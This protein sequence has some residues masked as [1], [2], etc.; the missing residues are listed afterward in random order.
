MTVPKTAAS[1]RKRYLLM[2]DSQTLQPA[3]NTLSS[4]VRTL[5]T[6]SDFRSAMRGVASEP[7][8]PRSSV[9]DDAKWADESVDSFF[10]RRF[11][12]TMAET[13]VSAIIHGIY[14]GDTRRLSMR[15]VFPAL[16]EAERAN[17]SVFRWLWAR[18]RRRT[19]ASRPFEKRRALERDLL[20]MV[21]D[22]IES[23]EKGKALATAMRSASV[24]GLKGG[25]QTLVDH[26][27]GRL[28]DERV[29][30]MT[31]T[32]IDKVERREDRWSLQLDD[33]TSLH[34]DHYVASSPATL[35]PSFSQPSIPKSTV[36]VVSLAF[37]PSEQ[38]QQ[39]L[40]PP[41][42][43][44]LIP[45]VIPASLNPHHA[46]GVIF[47]SDVMPGI[48]ASAE[49]GLTKLSILFGGSYWLDH[50][51]PANQ[52]T[53]DKLVSMA[54]ETL[55]MHFPSVVDWPEPVKTL[56][57]MQVDCIP[58]LPPGIGRD[59]AR[60]HGEMRA[61]NENERMPTVSVV[62]GGPSGVGINAVVQSAWEVGTSIAR[63]IEDDSRRV[64]TGL[65]RWDEAEQ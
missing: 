50:S 27:K 46:L 30:V 43:G 38:Q 42:F 15:A 56:S 29:Q 33:G 16:W 11:G 22:E 26:V 61:T 49:L 8:K 7:F 31:S 9:H 57:N 53:H 18:L 13:Y 25:L 45:R 21:Q 51:P 63:S 14:S 34:A 10:T 20:K 55:R 54:L 40:V 41:G 64:L 4:L 24:W 2:P 65:E 12:K 58:Q 44:Y 59:L 35:P 3:P 39:R 19:D 28:T 23:T 5:L 17:G 37:P 62:G 48:D 47:D 52:P 36:A 32:H 60:L 1:A 6:S